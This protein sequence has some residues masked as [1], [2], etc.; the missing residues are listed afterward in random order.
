MGSKSIESFI[1]GVLVGLS[2]VV[3]GIGTVATFNHMQVTESKLGTHYIFGTDHQQPLHLIE[4]SK[5]LSNASLSFK[6][7]RLK[8]VSSSFSPIFNKVL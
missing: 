4:R 6:Q 1:N 3:L 7:R 5:S 2:V 8:Y